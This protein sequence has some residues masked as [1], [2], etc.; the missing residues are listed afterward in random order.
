MIWSAIPGRMCVHML[1]VT[2]IALLLLLN[3]PLQA[4]NPNAPPSLKTIAVPISPTIYKYV[5]DRAAAVRLGKALFWDMQVG[6]DG[7]QAC[8]SCHAH[9]GADNR[10]KNSLNPGSPNLGGTV[11]NL[12]GAPNYTLKP[13]DFPFHLLSDPN[14]RNSTVLRDIDDV[15]SS[16]G[17]FGY[18][19]I[20]VPKP[21]NFSVDQGSL[22]YDSVFNV[23]GTNVRRVEPRQTPSIFNAAFNYRNF[24][25]GRAFVLFN[26]QNPF[27]PG[28]GVQLFRTDSHK[29]MQPTEI[30]TDLSSLASQAVGPVVSSMEMSY[31]ARIWPK[32]GKK[33]LSPNIV[34]LGKQHV[35]KT[36]SVLGRLAKT[37][38]GLG[39]DYTALIKDAFYSDYWDSRQIVEYIGGKPI[40]KN[41]PPKNT[42]QYTMMEANFSLFWG[43]A[44]QLYVASL[45]SDDSPYDRYQ[46]GNDHALTDQQK[47]GLDLFLNKGNCI[48]CHSTSLFSEATTPNILNPDGTA[49][50]IGRTEVVDGS[51]VV[52]DEGFFNTG[53][54]PTQEDLG[55]GG[56]NPYSK[57]LSFSIRAT[58]LNDPVKFSISPPAQPGERTAVTGAFKVPI[59]RNV[60]LTGPYFHNGGQATLNQVLDFYNRGGD[61]RDANATNV[62]AFITTLGLTDDEKA[63]IVAFLKSLTDDRVRYE[64]APFDHPEIFI[65][66]G[67]PVN[68]QFVIKDSTGRAVDD[69]ISIPAVGA[70]GSKTPLKPFFQ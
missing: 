42:N 19:F 70:E 1:I 45:I 2:C 40:I 64:R 69:L 10:I 24:W 36:D 39:T 56:N 65:P 22:Y 50:P 66:N 31:N 4:A 34:P 23:R 26:G 27:G 61:F 44:V 3:V 12:G 51:T 59:L 67:H 7:I 30:A 14:N 5:K 6:S 17:A 11:F 38:T 55:V 60:E 18:N 8:G 9:A 28:T 32:V 29:N 43:L 68:Q 33:M 49:S 13:S 35:S 15:V 46:E 16:Q 37:K 54:R 25:D 52:Y 48:Q 41:G 58:V 53:V 63:A 62:D 21:P 57:P 47:H 20:D